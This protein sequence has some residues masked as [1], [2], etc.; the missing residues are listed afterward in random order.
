MK[1][2]KKILIADDDAGILDALSLLLEDTGYEVE[3]ISDGNKINA[4]LDPLPDLL[5]LDVWMAGSDGRDICQAIKNDERTSKI[6]VIIISAHKDIKAVATEAK[7][8][9]YLAKP[10]QVKALLEKI[11]SLIG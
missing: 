9:D 1:P 10:F 8:D 2:S 4:H 7:A 6:P 3:I 11:Q 5:L